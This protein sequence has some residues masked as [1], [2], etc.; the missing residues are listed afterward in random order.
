MQS[1]VIKFPSRSLPPTN[2]VSLP[3]WPQ[4]KKLAAACE[5]GCRWMVCHGHSWTDLAHRCQSGACQLPSSPQTFVAEGLKGRGV[6]LLTWSSA[7]QAA[8]LGDLMEGSKSLPPWS[9][10][11]EYSARE[12]MEDPRP[13]HGGC[14]FANQ[15]SAGS[16][17]DTAELTWPQLSM[18]EHG[19][20]LCRSSPAVPVVEV[21]SLGTGRGHL[22][23]KVALLLPE[24]YS[25]GWHL[26]RWRNEE[27][28]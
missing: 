1:I 16:P 10:G 19:G 11:P 15:V 24:G 23:S 22:L 21:G 26:E 7:R 28:K 6:S 20:S 5:K 17:T 12:G 3:S 13:G 8:M 14:C 4:G 18:T 27:W 25:S 9:S 2:P